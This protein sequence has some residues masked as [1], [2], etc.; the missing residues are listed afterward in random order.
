[1]CRKTLFHKNFSPSIFKTQVTVTLACFSVKKNSLLCKH[2]GSAFCLYILY[3]VL[4]SPWDLGPESKAR[5]ARPA[6]FLLPLTKL[7]QQCV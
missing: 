1:M 4:N 3:G 7:I 2:T 5:E 6:S